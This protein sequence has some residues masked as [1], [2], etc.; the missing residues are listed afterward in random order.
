MTSD[1]A[2]RLVN[3]FGWA[4]TT[5]QIAVEAR[6]CCVYCDMPF[7]ET[8]DS[9]MQFNVDHIVPRAHGG[10][11]DVANLAASC[12]TCNRL[13]RTFNP[14]AS[15]PPNAPKADLIA[16]ARQHVS[17]RRTEKQQQLVTVKAL[18]SELTA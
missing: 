12:Q 16:A 15:L 11:E 6:F 2:K 18:A 8:W 7:L 9:Y 13:K 3:E 10:S 1:A 5:L 4:D 14:A 17:L